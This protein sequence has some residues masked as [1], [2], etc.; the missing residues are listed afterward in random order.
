MQQVSERRW[1]IL[2]ME[3]KARE[4]HAKMLLAL[5]AA[6]RGWGVLIGSKSAV[7][8]VQ[9]YLPRGTFLEKGVA[10]GTAAT[11][12]RAR[13]HGHRVSAVCEEGL[14]YFTPE[15]NRARRLDPRSMAAIDYFF[16]WGARHAADAHAVL[17]RD[18]EKVVISG[19]PRLDLVRP[20]WRGIF[21]PAVRQIR[22]R[23]GS[24]IL[25]NTKFPTVNNIVRT[26]GDYTDYLK[27]VGRITSPVHEALW[28]RFV[29]VQRNVF[30]HML[31]LVPALSRAF[32]AHTIVVR[33]HPSEDT[34]AWEE[35]AKGLSNV[36][37]IYEGNVLEWIMAADVVIQNNCLTAVEAFLLDKPTIAYRPYKDDPAEFELP[38]RLGLQASTEAEVLSLIEGVVRGDID[39]EAQASA[40][41]EVARQCIANMDGRLACDAIMETFDALDLPLC[42]AAFPVRPKGVGGSIARLKSLPVVKAALTYNRKKFPNLELAEM[43]GLRADFQDISGRF[44]DIEITQATADGF[45]LYRP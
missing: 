13:T 22:E 41:R 9:S 32:P 20:E 2:L 7:R 23:H 26:I 25:L 14:L 38:R 39:V 8:N 10:P 12:E 11:I 15:D 6:E 19:N 45:C 44:A 37:V 31:D 18:S 24:I 42:E 27:S 30:P 5:V 1:L 34:A 16:A 40:Q 35:K 43:E 28:R 4:L 36:R 33:P 17:E 3:T 29:A 21:A